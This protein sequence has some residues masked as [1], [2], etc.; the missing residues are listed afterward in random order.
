M[1]D[2][3]PDGRAKGNPEESRHGARS[4]PDFLRLL[5]GRGLRDDL[6]QRR[7]EGAQVGRLLLRLVE[8]LEET[9]ELAARDLLPLG[10]VPRQAVDPVLE[11]QALRVE[12]ERPCVALGQGRLDLV[13]R[14]ASSRS[15]RVDQ[16]LDTLQ[17]FPVFG[18]QGTIMFRRTA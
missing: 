7:K 3:A 8:L 16:R 4:A 5:G 15:A 10:D 17:E 13:S 6:A 18:H 9:G 2:S 12:R 14:E 1:P 11:A